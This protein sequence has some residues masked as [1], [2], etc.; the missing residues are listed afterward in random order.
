MFSDAFS[1]EKRWT[2]KAYGAEITDITSDNKQITR[3]LIR[4]AIARAGEMRRRPNHWWSDQL[5]NEDG[6]DAY[7]GLGDEIWGAD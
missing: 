6:A 3:E 5:N 1:D 7:L 2:M 4:A